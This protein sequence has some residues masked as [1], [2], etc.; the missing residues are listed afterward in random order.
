MILTSEFKHLIRTKKN[1]AKSS[2]PIVLDD[3]FMGFTDVLGPYHSRLI[4]RGLFRSSR[5]IRDCTVKELQR[6][7]TRKSNDG[8]LRRC[9][10]LE[11]AYRGFGSVFDKM[12]AI[13]ER[14]TANLISKVDMDKIKQSLLPPLP[15]HGAKIWSWD[16]LP[17]DETAVIIDSEE[18]YE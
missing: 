7:L 13:A 2:R 8:Y 9:C 4:S 11:L 12:R 14:S 17:A 10:E 6:A 15:T 5:R 16:L 3:S 1:K 18:S